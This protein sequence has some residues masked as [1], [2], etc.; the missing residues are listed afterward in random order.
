MTRIEPQP[1]LPVFDGMV[2]RHTFDSRVLGGDQKCVRGYGS[3]LEGVKYPSMSSLVCAGS[4]AEVVVSVFPPRQILD[5]R[6]MEIK[7]ER[8][9][10]GIPRELWKDI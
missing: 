5:P 9:V 3:L 2:Y 7:D 4:L 10:R 8:E 6:T 1:T